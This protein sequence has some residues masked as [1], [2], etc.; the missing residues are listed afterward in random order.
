MAGAR[1]IHVAVSVVVVEIFVFVM[2]LC[3][4]V[5]MEVVVEVTVVWGKSTGSRCGGDGSD[6]H[7]SVH[8]G[9]GGCDCD[10]CGEEGGRRDC[11]CWSYCDGCLEK[12]DG[13]STSC[14]DI[15]EKSRVQTRG[16]LIVVNW[17]G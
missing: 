9:N 5:A 4:C 8:V 3:V 10:I 14:A 2:V 7:H 1:G 6:S 12:D 17:T 11:H 13:E 15:I 16:H